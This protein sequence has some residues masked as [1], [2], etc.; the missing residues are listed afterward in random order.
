MTGHFGSLFSISEKGAEK[1]V[2]SARRPAAARTGLWHR[3]QQLH[4]T[5]AQAWPGISCSAVPRRPGSRNTSAQT[6]RASPTV[7]TPA[8]AE[9]TVPTCSQARPSRAVAHASSSDPAR[10]AEGVS[11]VPDVVRPSLRNDL[12][13]KLREVRNVLGMDTLLPE[14]MEGS[15]MARFTKVHDAIARSGGLPVIDPSSTIDPGGF[16]IDVDQVR[17]RSA[18]LSMR[19]PPRDALIHL[20]RPSHGGRAAAQLPA[21]RGHRAPGVPPQVPNGEEPGARHCRAPPRRPGQRPAR[22]LPC[23]LALHAA[24]H[25]P[26]PTRLPHRHAAKCLDPNAAGALDD[27]L[28]KMSEEISN[29]KSLLTECL[30]W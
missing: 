12:Y 4:P 24:L 23:A 28:G 10:P 3:R 17:G 29:A 19:A 25:A 30:R 6:R 20:L 14:V 27:C 11:R 2:V 13:N 21:Q 7:Q 26:S 22:G 8:P 9:P 16:Q 18:P 5:R 1:M 15:L